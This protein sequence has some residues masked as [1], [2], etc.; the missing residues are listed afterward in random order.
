MNVIKAI[1]EKKISH[2][3][4]FVVSSTD[5][6]VKNDFFEEIK[7]LCNKNNIK[8]YS[9]NDDF[10]IVTTHIIAI[11]WRWIIKKNEDQKL[12][13]LHDSILP[14]YRGFC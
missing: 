4:N 7:T 13:V 2:H 14:K 6:N 12:I 10:E 5:L 9:K 1:I 3:I 8:F 11:S